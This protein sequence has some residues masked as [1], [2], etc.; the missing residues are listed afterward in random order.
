MF[1]PEGW[2]MSVFIKFVL[3]FIELTMAHDRKES[4]RDKKCQGQKKR[5]A[6]DREKK[7]WHVTEKR[8]AHYIKEICK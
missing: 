4:A 5:M 1:Y 2:E 8:L 3:I 6:H 7:E